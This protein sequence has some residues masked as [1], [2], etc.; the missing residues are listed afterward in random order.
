MP[1]PAASASLGGK[2]SKRF[3]LDANTNAKI[4]ASVAIF[5]AEDTRVFRTDVAGRPP[6]QVGRWH[7][8]RMNDGFDW[9]K[10]RPSLED[11]SIGEEE[12]EK[13]DWEDIWARNA[14]GNVFPEGL[15]GLE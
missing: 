15:K 7:A 13:V 2:G 6:V 8:Y 4:C 3:R 11:T 5:R 14:A 9:D 10:G 12:E 1:L